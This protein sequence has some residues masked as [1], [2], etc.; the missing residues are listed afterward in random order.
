VTLSGGAIR[1]GYTVRI[2]NKT[3][4]KRDFDLTVRG[5]DRYAMSVVGGKDVGDE[6]H[7]LAVTTTPDGVET[8]RLYVTAASDAQLR[9]GSGSE[10]RRLDETEIAVE[11]RDRNTGERA[12]HHSI[13]IAPHPRTERP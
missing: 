7:S 2:L 8:Y 4:E 6:A 13:F 12:S 11:V 1:N 3:H 5:L 9:S 10:N